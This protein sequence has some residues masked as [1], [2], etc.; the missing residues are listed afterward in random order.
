MV[1]KGSDALYQFFPDMSL[2]KR[3]LLADVVLTEFEKYGMLP[4]NLVLINSPATT[5][6]KSE[7]AFKWEIEDKK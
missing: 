6:K 1:H 4:P 2:E 7:I 5:G 3:N